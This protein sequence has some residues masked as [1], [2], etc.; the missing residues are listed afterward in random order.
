MSVSDRFVCTATLP[1]QSIEAAVAELNRVIG[2]GYKAVFLP[3]TP[4]EQVGYYNEDRW[5]PL[6]A[7]AEEAG[8]VLAV[9]IGTD[10]GTSPVKYKNPGGNIINFVDTTFGGQRAVVQIT[11]SG[12][13]ERHPDLKVLVSEGGASWVPFI[14][15]RMNEGFR[16]LPMFDEKR[17]RLTP[18]EY[19]FRNV[20]ASFQ[21]DV[22]AVTAMTAMGYQNVAWGSD[23]PH[24]EGTFP[25]TQ[26]V[27]A[28]LFEGV[29]DIVRE[30]ITIGS[31]LDLFPHVG[32]PPAMPALAQGRVG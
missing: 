31:F 2:L 24:L 7:A 1:L 12:A 8:V 6:W 13:F 29:S 3:T 27:L 25:H 9:H 10:A 21:H 20:Y 17:L 18:K 11:A 5:E 28:G 30:R 23:Y 15:D 19:L 14:G 32:R 16:Q 26:E 22:S 4:P